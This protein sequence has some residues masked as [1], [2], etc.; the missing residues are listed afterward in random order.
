[1]AKM[2]VFGSNLAGYTDNQIAP[3]FKNAPSNCELPLLWR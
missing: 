3:M 1:M 2:F